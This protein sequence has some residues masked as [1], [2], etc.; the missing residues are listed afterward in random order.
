MDVNVR[1][2]HF[3]VPAHVEE[4]ARVKFEK[5]AH[6]L[7]LLDDAAVE[8]DFAH[9]KAK[10]P[11]LRYVVHVTVSAHGVHLQAEERAAQPE[12]A[13]D[14]AARVLSRQAR[15]HKDRLYGRA[16]GKNSKHP[17]AEPAPAADD[18]ASGPLAKVAVVERVAV[19]PMSVEEAVDQMD[20]LGRPFLLFHDAGSNGFALLYRRGDGAYGLVLPEF[21]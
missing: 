15:Q 21:P 6:Y 2:K 4:R 1:G 10:E 20:L 3:D 9:E 11:A 19:K 18:E 17:E 16:R 7:P 14:Q 13:V 12:A 5:L 8:V